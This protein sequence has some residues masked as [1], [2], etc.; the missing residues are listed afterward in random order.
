MTETMIDRRAF[1]A[2]LGLTGLGIAAAT[3]L[4]GCAPTTLTLVPSADDAQDIAVTIKVIDNRYEPAEVSIR[5]GQAVRWE[6]LGTAKHDVVADDRSFVSA[7]MADGSYTHV[8]DTPGDFA[9]LC[10]IHAEM[11]GVVSVS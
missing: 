11:R 4:A 3:A 10:S 8:F 2:G 7:L 5:A 9:Y 1:L 6:F